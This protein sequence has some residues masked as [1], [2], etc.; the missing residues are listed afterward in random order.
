MGKELVKFGHVEIETEKF[1]SSKSPVD[2][3]NVSI[4]KIVICD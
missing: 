3:E 4:D 2:M 1:H